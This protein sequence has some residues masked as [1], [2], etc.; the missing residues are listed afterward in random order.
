[1]KVVYVFMTLLFVTGLAYGMSCCGSDSGGHPSH[2][3]NPAVTQSES[4]EHAGHVNYAQKLSTESSNAEVQQDMSNN[5][6]GGECKHN[7]SNIATT[8]ATLGDIGDESNGIEKINEKQSVPEKIVYVCPMNCI[9]G[10]TADKPGRCPKCGMYLKPKKIKS[11]KP[12]FVE[13]KYVCP[14]PGECCKDGTLYD[15]PGKCPRC[16]KKLV[17]NKIIYSFECPN[18]KC[19]YKISENDSCPTHKKQLKKVQVKLYCP[20]DNSEL[21]IQKDSTL[22]CQQCKL[23][24]SPDKVIIKDVETGK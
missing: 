13:T 19:Y 5:E 23:E 18:K 21:V 16:S 10:F 14:C 11:K 9:P 12:Y 1:M 15:K 24:I 17:E 2:Y 6:Q 8:T 7:V 20:H 4:T 22:Y 3:T